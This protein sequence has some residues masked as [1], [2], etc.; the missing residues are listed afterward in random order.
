MQNGE[1]RRWRITCRPRDTGCPPRATPSRAT[2]PRATSRCHPRAISR[3]H[4]R[5]TPSRAIPRNSAFPDRQKSLG[6]FFSPRRG[7]VSP[8]FS[9]T[10]RALPLFRMMQPP[11]QQQQQGN[12]KDQLALPPKDER[13]RTEVSRARRSHARSADRPVAF[14]R[15]STP[16]APRNERPPARS[17]RVR[18]PIDRI[19]PRTP[20]IR[21][22]T[23]VGNA[24]RTSARRIARRV[25]TY[26]RR[27]EP[28]RPGILR[29]GAAPPGRTQ[30]CEKKTSRRSPPP[31]L[32]PPR[33]P[34]STFH[35]T[36][37]H[38]DQGQR[39]RRLL[40]Q[41][42]APHGHLRKRL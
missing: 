17:R 35:E 42:R 16:R 28:E 31:S 7:R 3:C 26:A 25:G 20:R 36:G 38:R 21:I 19:D 18:P 41:A 14:R 23:H 34:P 40:P 33:V 5:D 15:G 11:P 9:L 13:Y 12:W 27:S 1:I 10:P 6:T 29:L 8:N 30:L 24:I 37:R 32:T 39:V 22:V 4:R 2:R